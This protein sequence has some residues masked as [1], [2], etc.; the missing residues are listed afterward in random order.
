MAA[1]GAVGQQRVGIV[2]G[3]DHHAARPRD[4]GVTA[5]RAELAARPADEL[6]DVAVIVGEQD[7]LLDVLGRRAGV[8]AEAGEREIG[9]QRVEQRQRARIVG[10]DPQA[11]GDLVADV[12][13][14]GGGEMAR[15]IGGRD[16]VEAQRMAGIEDIGEGDFLPPRRRMDLDVIVLDQ[17]GELLDQI[18]GEDR[19]LGDADP[20]FAGLDQPPERADRRGAAVAALVA[21]ADLG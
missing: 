15:E 3:L 2:A 1:P 11:V 6:V 7:I 4:R 12:R 19:G 20:V 18:F 14:L 8:V 9:A 10:R 5:A 13:Q 17:E 16:L 21:Q